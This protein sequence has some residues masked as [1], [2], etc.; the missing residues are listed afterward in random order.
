MG[1]PAGFKKRMWIYLKEMYPPHIRFLHAIL[2][3]S[4]FTTLLCHIHHQTFQFFSITSIIGILNVF[5]VMLMLRIMDEL[6]DREIDSLLFAK[7]A[8]PAGKVYEKDLKISLIAVII[9]F[10]SMNA[11]YIRVLFSAILVLMYSILMFKFFF[12]PNILRKNLLLNLAT[13]NPVIVLILFHLFNIFTVQQYM[14]YSQISWFDVIL[15]ILLFWLML[16]SWEISRKI[17]SAEEETAYVTYSQIFG[18]VGAMLVASSAQTAALLIAIYFA[19]TLSLSWIFLSVLSWGFALMLFG[20]I[21]FL[22]WP[23]PRH[24]NLRSFTEI[25]ILSFMAAMILDSVLR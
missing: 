12:I 6:K 14:N 23:N 5:T 20:Y 1:I 3:Y 11:F 25:Y 10:I 13:H 15:L 16:F 24:S 19:F 17:R 18:R 2:L 4:T 8:F 9:T 21:C 7:R 22:K